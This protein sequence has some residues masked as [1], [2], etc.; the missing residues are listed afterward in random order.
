MGEG[1][2]GEAVVGCLQHV[3]KGLVCPCLPMALS[4]FHASE[5]LFYLIH[6]FH[7]VHLY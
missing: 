5:F 7:L 4:L 1:E 2:R 3:G 6:F